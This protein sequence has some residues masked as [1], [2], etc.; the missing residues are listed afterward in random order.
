MPP[1]TIKDRQDE[2]MNEDLLKRM[3]PEAS[4]IFRTSLEAVDPYQAVSFVRVDDD[5]LEIGGEGRS[6]MEFHLAKYDRISI[7]GGR[8]W[9]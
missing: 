5:R 6:N 7:V 2:T 9:E 8:N 1:T 4:E 3:R